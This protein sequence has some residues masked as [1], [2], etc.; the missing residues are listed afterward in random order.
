M[1]DA[2]Q[3]PQTKDNGSPEAKPRVLCIDELAE[4]LRTPEPGI[5]TRKYISVAEAAARL[6]CTLNDLLDEGL[7]G[8]RVIYAPVLDEGLYAWPVTDRGM[9]HSKVL[10]MAIPVFRR[11]LSAGDIG[12]LTHSDIAQIRQG[13]PVIPEGYVLPEITSRHIDTWLAEQAEVLA[14]ERMRALINK[15]VWIHPSKL[16][17]ERDRWPFPTRMLGAGVL[18]VDSAGMSE[19]TPLTIKELAPAFRQYLDNVHP[20][21][22]NKITGEGWERI[23]QK[24]RRAMRSAQ[25]ETTQG[26]EGTWK[27]VEV[28]IVLHEEY[29]YPWIS[30]NQAFRRHELL[31]LWWPVWVKATRHRDNEKVDE[32]E[33]E[34]SSASPFRG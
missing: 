29:G 26:R 10:G 6:G 30:L 5:E 15:V 8:K 22:K 18:L 34:P 21:G 11:R 4:F 2:D 14:S 25:V 33:G 13:V 32:P 24:P 23:F 12:I 16:D 31:R 20:G 27:P 7:A 17:S 3:H 19:P 9:P 28:G 1:E